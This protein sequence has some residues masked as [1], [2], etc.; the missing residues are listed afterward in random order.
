MAVALERVT[1]HVPATVANLGPGF[2]C[3]GA[4]VNLFAEVTLAPAS[5]PR[6]EVAGVDVPQD[7][8][9]LIYR[10]AQAAAAAAGWQGAFAL[11]ARWPIPLRSGLGSSAA[12][13]VG[14]L[15]AAHRLLG[16]ALDAQTLLRLATDLEGHPDNVAAALFGGVVV[17]ARDG[18][19]VRWAR[20]APVLPLAVVLAVP[21][22][23]IETAAAR[24]VLPAQVA[25]ADAVF[26]VARTALVVTALATGQAQALRG[27]LRDRLHQ[28]YR[29]PLVPGFAAVVAAAEDAGAYGAVLSGSGPT[30]AALTPPAAAGAVGAAMVAAFAAAGVQSRALE[31]QIEL[32][33]ALGG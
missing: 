8:T 16:D 24:R 19:E 29:A 1:V 31:T 18:S 33:G 7:A 14:G 21:A 6:V 17:V 25:H 26:N 4:A 30:V 10:S 2:D 9:N 28:P 5:T 13:I 3:L 20:I 11:R 27:A 23:E 32:R 12:A 15:V 22:L